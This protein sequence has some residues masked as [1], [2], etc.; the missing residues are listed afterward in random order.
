MPRKRVVVTGIGTINPLGSDVA[1]YFRNLDRGVSGA[2]LIDRFDTTLFKTRFACEIPD[3]NPARFP[4]AIDRKEA[5]KT[6]PFTQ[7]AMIAA[8]E[9][10]RP[11]GR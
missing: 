9:A 4:E 1:E 8:S 7:Y 10:V 6:D 3:Y 2:R 11:H 5:R